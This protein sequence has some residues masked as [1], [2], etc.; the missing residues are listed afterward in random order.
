MKQKTIRLAIAACAL[1]VLTAPV[2][3]LQN[4]LPAKPTLEQRLAQTEQKLAKLA[5]GHD[6][7]MARLT[8]IEN[9][10]DELLKKMR[11]FRAKLE[12][13]AGK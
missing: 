12:A 13:K 5:S 8:K 3:A 6:A 11:D 1:V 7:F 10:M 9:R 4:A 2:A